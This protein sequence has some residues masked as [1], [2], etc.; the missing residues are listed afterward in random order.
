VTIKPDTAVAKADET[1]HPHDAILRACTVK[2][3]VALS[4]ST[5]VTRVDGQLSTSSDK[6]TSS[7]VQ[8]SG[9][10]SLLF[11]TYIYK[12]PVWLN[13][14]AFARDPKVAGSNQ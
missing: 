10:R 9:F 12:W 1:V 14:R 3:M 4:C 8:G 13:G 2:G 6:L 11:V 7:I 5:Q